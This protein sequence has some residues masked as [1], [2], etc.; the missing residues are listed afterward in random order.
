MLHRLRRPPAAP[1]SA[2]PQPDGLLQAP[3]A[4]L[5][6][7]QLVAL[8]A[9]VL[10]VLAAWPLLLVPVPPFQDLPNHLATAHIIAH[11][12]L[13]PQFAFNG[14]FKSNG[15]QTL[16]LAAWTSLAGGAHLF[17]AARAFTAIVLAVNAVAWPVFVLRFAG[18]RHVPAAALLVW[19]LVHGFFVVMGMLN[20]AFGFGL[21]LILLAI[22]DGQRT[23]PTLARGAG[24]A[25]LAGLLWFAHPFP[26]A[27]VGAL[28]GLHVLRATTWPARFAAGRA[29]LL[30]L[31]PAVALSAMA[32]ERHLVKAAHSTAST[33][34]SFSYLNPFE[35]VEHLW[36][37]ASGALTRWGSVTVVPLALLAYLAWRR[38][39]V[40]RPYFSRAALLALAIG[41]VAIPET[42]SNW[43]YFGC[44]LVPFL[45]AGLAL[46]LPARL[47]RVV[48]GMLVAC[49]LAFSAITGAD[50]VR[51]E[52]DRVAFTAGMN[53]VPARATL[54]PLLFRK[55]ETSDFTE[56]LT[57]AWAYYLI[58]KDTSA[59]LAFAV[60]RSYPITYREFPPR[61]L[62]PP[63]LE[64]FAER[65]GTPAQICRAM[66]RV[67]P[68]PI[69]VD[70]WRAVWAAFWR[71]ATPRFTH[72]LTWGMPQEARS[73]IPPA[74]RRA[75][76][77]GPLAIYVHQPERP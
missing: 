76:E 15:L 59:P 74:Y 46:R 41:Y 54:L 47:P 71:D 73:L 4:A 52:R 12:D 29:Q 34:L 8:V 63:A 49:A 51:L 66:D 5:T 37:D 58:E 45:W 26:L 36:L 72:L 44:R 33:A 30:P 20:F 38:R 64:S 14:F 65:S 22:L 48:T 3:L 62:I 9:S 23:R 50:Y 24:S 61:A 75:F 67:A 42:F 21:S 31:L 25:A 1:P 56:S 10:F 6:D 11:P 55:S 43:S 28:V 17:A 19:P 32:A 18:R 16:W 70:A 57:H 40:E 39:D 60:E 53:A 69:C 27:L 2:E 7:G 68:D 13:Y 35:L 77:A